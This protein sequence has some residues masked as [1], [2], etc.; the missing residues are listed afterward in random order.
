[1][2]RELTQQ[3]L[4][5]QPAGVVSVR[6]MLS[7]FD[8]DRFF[9]KSELAK[10][11]SVSTRTIEKNLDEIPHYRLHGSMLR[12]KKSEIDEWTAQF[13]EDGN[14]LDRIADEAIESLKG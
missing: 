5:R 6:E 10:Y 7:Y 2:D 11:L 1:M 8:A 3:D 4:I 9:N 14:N 13:R 12:F